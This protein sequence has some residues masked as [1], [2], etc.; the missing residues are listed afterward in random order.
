MLNKIPYDR[1][2]FLDNKIKTESSNSTEFFSMIP[3]IRRREKSKRS[4]I[5]I[6]IQT[7]RYKQI[8]TNRQIQTN[9]YRQTD[10][11]KQIQTNR[12]K[13]TDTDRYK[14]I[15]TDRYRQIRC[16]RSHN[17]TQFLQIC[18]RF[19]WIFVEHRNIIKMNSRFCGIVI[20]RSAVSSR[21]STPWWK[22]IA[23]SG[24]N[25]PF[26]REQTHYR[27]I[28][29]QNAT[30]RNR[31]RQAD[32]SLDWVTFR[33]GTA[34]NSITRGP[35]SSSANLSVAANPWERSPTWP[36]GSTTRPREAPNCPAIDYTFWGRNSPSNPP[37]TVRT[38]WGGG[39]T[40]P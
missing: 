8:D 13:L 33:R 27:Q 17:S 24:E 6:Q 23:I 21:S 40:P 31:R 30:M 16:H 14:Q 29:L 7:D 11:D 10:T 15:Q 37:L 32:V 12:Y 26:T 22:C 5:N 3:S 28:N 9:R 25:P 35:T 4:C 34:A 1:K 20:N 38:S 19:I 2:T 39:K 18:C 36:S